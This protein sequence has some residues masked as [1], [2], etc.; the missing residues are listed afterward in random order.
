MKRAAVIVASI[1]AIA[2]AGGV[3]VKVKKCPPVPVPAGPEAPKADPPIAAP[4]QPPASPAPPVNAP[5]PVADA[6]K[7]E[8]KT[9]A[10]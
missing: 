6:D 8:Q 1:V 5:A 4:A 2:I 7:P 10:K 3:I 9:E